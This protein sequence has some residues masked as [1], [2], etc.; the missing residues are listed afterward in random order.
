MRIVRFWRSANELGLS[1]SYPLARQQTLP[2]EAKPTPTPVPKKPVVPFSQ[3][4]ESIL[5]E[6]KK[7][8]PQAKAS[9]VAADEAAYSV[10]GKISIFG[11][12]GTDISIPT[13]PT[14]A[15]QLVFF[16]YRN[17]S[18]RRVP[19]IR[20][21]CGATRWG[22]AASPNSSSHFKTWHGRY[23]SLVF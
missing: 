16:F 17:R 9:V 10:S 18:G 11:I 19:K 12:Y 21:A 2:A 13:D 6:W 14:V 7:Q 20:T 8:A 23:C 3:P 4:D 1:V 5:A 15:T 22:R